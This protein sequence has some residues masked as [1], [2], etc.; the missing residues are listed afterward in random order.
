[1]SIF[2]EATTVGGQR[3]NR[4]KML[5]MACELVSRFRFSAEDKQKALSACEHLAD[6]LDHCRGLTLQQRWSDFET[7]IWPRWKDGFERPCSL[8]T[9]GARVLVPSRMVVPSLEWLADVRV[10]QW[11]ARLPKDH[12]LVQQHNLLL[13]ATAP[14]T[15]TSVHNRHLAVCNGLRILLAHG[16]E[17]L[18]QIQDDDLKRL[19]GRW[20]KGTDALDAALCSLGVFARTPRRGSTRHSRKRRLTASE[21]VEIAQVPVRFRQIMVLYLETYEARV[22]DVYRTLRHK[23]IALAHFWRFIGEHH[24]DVKR[25]SAILPRHVRDY[26]P[27]ALARARAVQRGPGAGEEVRPTA[28]S[29][30]VELRTFFSDI[31]AWATEAD[32]PFAPFAPRTIPV[33][34]HTFQGYGFEKARARTRA[35]LTETV[36]ELEREMPKIRAFALQQWK[37]AVAAPKIISSRGYPWSDE[38]DT[39]W[40]WALLELLVQSGVR[41]EEASEL[42]TLDILRRS[43]PD[44]RIYYLLH[45]KPSK[46]DRAR[47][48]PIGD[49]LGRVLA[50]IIRYVKRFYNSASVPVCDHWD[51]AEKRPRPPAPYLLQGIR[52]P[53]ATGIQTI[54]DRI[55]ELSIRAE[56]RRSDGSAL[57]LL[58]HD[59]RRVF[60]SEH[61]N[62]N[63]PVHVIQALLGH[64]SPDT[65]M[66]YAKLYPSRLIEEYRKTVRGLYNAYYGE[67]GLKNPTAEEWNAFATNCNLRDMGTHICALPTG[68]YC[69]NGLICLGCPQVQPKK[70][71]VPLLQRMLASH[72]RSLSAAQDHHEPAGQ[73]ASRELEIVRIRG[74]LQRAEELSDDV[75]AAIEGAL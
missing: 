9:W 19:N 70:T 55:R 43:L 53:S 36:L 38:V 64:A 22:S 8:W 72:Q 28:H 21:L 66:I 67:D 37:S 33:T 51:L 30:L 69:A 23:S 59:C 18:R 34:R 68:E 46:F 50:E 32:S 52:H 62:N 35:R 44:K 58:P 5:S 14:I 2:V 24:P 61:L 10:N 65:V 71:A 29:W 57:V 12:P 26:I 25:C 54:R 16:Y 47:V 42:T 63:T 27:Y 31:C 7:K 75:A 6:A 45:I 20:S 41:I 74:V 48:I 15:W 1:M 40:D 17:H 4:N 49:S 60:A 13:R 73:I 56:A 39:F 11:I 3:Y